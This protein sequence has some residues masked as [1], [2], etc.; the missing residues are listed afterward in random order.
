MEPGGLAA[1]LVAECRPP[2]TNPW[3]QRVGIGAA[4]WLA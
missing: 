3:V 1:S 4:D 2:E